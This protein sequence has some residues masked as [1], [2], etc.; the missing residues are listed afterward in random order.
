ML[1]DALRLPRINIS[2]REQEKM[3]DI[4]NELPNAKAV[5]MFYENQ[6]GEY[7]FLFTDLDQKEFEMLFMEIHRHVQVSEFFKTLIET[8]EDVRKDFAKANELI[9]KGVDY[10]RLKKPIENNLKSKL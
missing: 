4:L 5:V 7:K 10:I 8:I 2:E 9:I 1:S 6:K 3:A